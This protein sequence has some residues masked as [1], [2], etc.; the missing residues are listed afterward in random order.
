M[1]YIRDRGIIPGIKVQYSTEKKYSFRN[2][3]LGG[4]IFFKKSQAIFSH[5]NFISTIFVV[6]GQGD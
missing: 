6:G 4:A 1:D 2:Q 3:A 5:L